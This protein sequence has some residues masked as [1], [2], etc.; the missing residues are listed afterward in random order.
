MS[1]PRAL[2]RAFAADLETDRGRPSLGL[3]PVQ[4]DFAEP[5]GCQ[6]W[7]CSIRPPRNTG[8]LALIG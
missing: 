7:G 4:T 3:P 6:F 2:R 1:R 8:I 5:T